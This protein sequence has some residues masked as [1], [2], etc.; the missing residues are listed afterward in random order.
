M[1]QLA[2]PE[3]LGRFKRG[4]GTQSYDPETLSGLLSAIWIIV[5][6]LSVIYLVIR[7]RKWREDNP[8]EN[9]VNAMRVRQVLRQAVEEG[10]AVH[11]TPPRG[12]GGKQL[13]FRPIE[14]NERS[15]T[16]ESLG[17]LGPSSNWEGQSLECR[18]QLRDLRNYVARRQYG[19]IAVALE[20]ERFDPVTATSGKWLRLGLPESIEEVQRRRSER[21]A[22]NPPVRVEAMLWPQERF[23]WPP[24]EG[25]LSAGGLPLR[26]SGS[27][28]AGHG[29]SR[30]PDGAALDVSGGGMR[31]SLPK[32]S[33]RGRESMF[34][35][36]ARHVVCLDLETDKNRVER[37]ILLART[38]N[39]VEDYASKS[40]EIGLQFIRRG[41]IASD[42]QTVAWKDLSGGVAEIDL[43]ARAAS[44][45]AS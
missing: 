15:L 6:V 9:A 45:R 25:R 3:F 17:R 29:G 10:V 40:V 27:R 5:A 8:S 14:L 21:V 2:T 42:S 41:R 13:E 11:V 31:L 1:S 20:V 28:G 30:G 35:L 37:Y 32:A 16:L 43:W 39:S 36:G 38:Q 22:A 23:Q 34:A 33:T 26:F 4:F 18:V 24:P 44:N 19:F 7:W 12:S